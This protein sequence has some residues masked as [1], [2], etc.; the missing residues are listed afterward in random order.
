[1][2]NMN[3]EKLFNPHSVAM[4]GASAKPRKW[5][6]IILLNILKGNFKGKIYPVNPQEKSILGYRCYTSVIDIPEVPDL[7]IITT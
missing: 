6:F 5:G 3:L 7:A 1:M 2:R 4:I